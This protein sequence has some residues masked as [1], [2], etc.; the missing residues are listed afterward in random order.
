[1]T[2]PGHASFQ[3]VEQDGSAVTIAVSGEIDIASAP[4]LRSYLSERVS[5]G[6]TEITLD[7]TKMT[8]IDS[9]GLGV[10]V[11]VI[12]R[13]RLEDGRLIICNPPPIAVQVL[14]VSG[15][16]PSLEIVTRNPAGALD[17]PAEDV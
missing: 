6:Y 4:A 17:S 7:L 14:S 5:E 8:F 9:S 10:I 15:L 16:T 13:L 2:S 1:M 12:N 3:I 11:G